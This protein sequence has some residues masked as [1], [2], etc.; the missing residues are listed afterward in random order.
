MLA[1]GA[2]ER[3]LA[4]A[5]NDRPGVMLAGAARAYLHRYG[6]LVGRR[7][8]V[9]TTNDSAYAAARDLA[10]AGLDIAAIVD[11]RPAPAVAGLVRCGPGRRSSPATP[12]TASPAPT[13]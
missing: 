13:G 11:T 3:P 1:T 5:D 8:V 7:A 4:F 2:H 9:F 6:V 12:C 10:A